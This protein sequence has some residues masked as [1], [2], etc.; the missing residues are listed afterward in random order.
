MGGGESVCNNKRRK[1]RGRK[2]VTVTGTGRGREEEKGERR[3]A[4]EREGFCNR[5]RMRKNSTL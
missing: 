1:E 3:G 4:L 5:G 2:R